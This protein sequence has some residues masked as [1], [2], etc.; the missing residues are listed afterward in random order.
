[1]QEEDMAL[2]NL[3]LTAAVTVPARSRKRT[4]APSAA[5]ALSADEVRG[6]SREKKRPGSKDLAPGMRRYTIVVPEEMVERVKH[7]VAARWGL[8]VMETWE[9]LVL[10][11]LEAFDAGYLPPMEDVPAAVRQLKRPE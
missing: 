3:D 9:G 5:N 7:E 10:L 6:V 8:K 4:P 2:A 11:G 1:M